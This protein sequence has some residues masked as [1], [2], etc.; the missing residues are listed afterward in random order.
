MKPG[1]L[2]HALL[3]PTTI[4]AACAA[5]PPAP[6]KDPSS[7]AT[8]ASSDMICA[9]EYPTGSYIA[10]MKCRTREQVESERLG[11]E[12]GLRRAQTGGPNAQAGSVGN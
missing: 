7:T 5:D 11:A 8:V 10:V 2:L 6:A 12:R 4:L 1:F 3:L 9:K